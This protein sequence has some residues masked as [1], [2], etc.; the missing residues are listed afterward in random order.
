M[1]AVL[2]DPAFLFVVE[3]HC[4]LIAFP[5]H[6]LISCPL[7]IGA[8]LFWT[9]CARVCFLKFCICCGLG[10]GTPM[11]SG[12]VVVG[13]GLR[14]LLGRCDP[15]WWPA[16]PACWCLLLL[17]WLLPLLLLCVRLST[18][19]GP[20]LLDC[21][22]WLLPLRCVLGLLRRMWLLPRWLGVGVL[23]VVTAP[24][25]CVLHLRMGL[26]V[27][28][29]WWPLHVAWLLP[30]WEVVVQALAV[31]VSGGPHL[32]RALSGSCWVLVWLRVRVCLSALAASGSSTA[33]AAL[34]VRR[35]LVVP[36]L[37]VAVW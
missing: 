6:S 11:R 28:L 20:R 14:W 15:C 32:R 36:C 35:L 10:Q 25:L 2:F 23:W 5:P 34:R 31:S 4:S 16:L 37:C 9:P 27:G 24:L 26:R 1:L 13:S 17:P 18:L 12:L 33:A 29:V 3:L 30:W 8:P 7:V 21:R 22:V 19:L